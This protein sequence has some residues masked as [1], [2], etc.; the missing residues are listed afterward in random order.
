MSKTKLQFYW[1]EIRP[2]ETIGNLWGQLAGTTH[3]L[4]FVVNMLEQLADDVTLDVA[5]MIAGLEYNCYGY[6]YVVYE[7]RERAVSLVGSI[8]SSK[9]RTIDKLKGNLKRPEE[10]KSALSDVQRV[11]P[12]LTSALKHLLVV[13]DED[14]KLRNLHTHEIFLSLGLLTNH[15]VYDPQ[16]VLNFDLHDNPV[17]RARFAD[18]LRTE[19]KKL[20]EE[21]RDK[22]Q[23]AIKAAEDLLH[24]STNDSCREFV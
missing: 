10:R 20:A 19:S 16:D 11:A 1:Y 22:A 23:Q 17:E 13:V 15:G 5:E 2:H 9:R 8:Y 4:R 18:F 3:K 24:A 21:Y 6:Y 7:M 12:H 14:I